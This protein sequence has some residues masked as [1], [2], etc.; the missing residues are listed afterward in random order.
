MAK[1]CSETI[2]LLD[3]PKKTI[4]KNTIKK[5]KKMNVE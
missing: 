5:K 3:S 2:A 4:K 1:D